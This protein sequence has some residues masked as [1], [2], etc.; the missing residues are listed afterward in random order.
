MTSYLTS[1][2]YKIYYVD[3]L[4]ILLLKGFYLG[5]VFLGSFGTWVLVLGEWWLLVVL[6]VVEKDY[7]NHLLFGLFFG[8]FFGLNLYC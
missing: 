4:V 6:G 2:C 8:L 5:L 3:T 7:G 1:W